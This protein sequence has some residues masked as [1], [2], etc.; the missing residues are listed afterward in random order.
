VATYVRSLYLHG[1]DD[2]ALGVDF[3]AIRLTTCPQRIQHSKS[4][5]GQ[6][7]SCTWSDRI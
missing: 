4:S 6:G 5:T 3:S 1:A 2:G 7:I